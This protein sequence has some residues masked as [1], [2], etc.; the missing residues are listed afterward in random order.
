MNPNVPPNLCYP[1]KVTVA[2][3]IAE[4]TG[5]EMEAMEGMVAVVHCSKLKGRVKKKYDYLGYK[6]CTGASLAFAG[7]SDCRYGCVGF[8]ECAD[9]CPFDAISMVDEFPVIDETRCVACGVC[10]KAC[11]KGLIEVIPKD[12]R[13]VVRCRSKETSK[14][15]LS[16]CETGCIH[17]LACIRECPAEAISEEN[18]GSVPPKRSRKKTGL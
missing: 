2:K 16:I 10:V 12:A 11:P 4:I 1:G 13:V 15:T 17:C 5:K 3:K 6:N 9:A 18:G 14:I 8:G 7:P